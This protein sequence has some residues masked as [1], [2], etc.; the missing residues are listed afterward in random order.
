MLLRLILQ[1]EL[2]TKEKPEDIPIVRETK[3]KPVVVLQ[4]IRFNISHSA[5]FYFIGISKNYEIGIDIQIRRGPIYPYPISILSQAEQHY[6]QKIKDPQRRLE[7]FL[8]IFTVKE[9]FS[10]A[11]GEG[12]C[13]N[14]NEVN[15][16]PKVLEEEF[17]DIVDVQDYK[18]VKYQCKICST[19]QYLSSI[20]IIKTRK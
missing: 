4:P 7:I 18:N 11:L 20:V 12:I 14:F 2:G 3:H 5:Q 6:F 17:E 15:L 9:A 1:K 13:L 16:Y 10:K 8:R 19:S